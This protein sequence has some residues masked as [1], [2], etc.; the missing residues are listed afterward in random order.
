[1]VARYLRKRSKLFLAVAGIVFS[2]VTGVVDYSAG[3]DTSLEAFYLLSIVGVAFF[4][5]RRAGTATALASAAIAV[6][7]DLK[8]HPAILYWDEVMTL[9]VFLGAAWI[10]AV[11]KRAV[12]REQ[13]LARTDYLTRAANRRAFFETAGNEISRARRYPRPLT[14]AYV[15]LDNFKPVN[16]RFGHDVGDH[17]LCMVTDI[18]KSNT[19]THD[20]VA[21]LGGDEFAILLPETGQEP[22]RVVMDRIHTRLTEAMR[23]KGWPVTF[24]VGVVTFASPPASVDK[25][26][27]H[28]DDLMYAAKRGGKDMILYEVANPSGAAI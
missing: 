28:A 5:G 26:I 14:V 27:K 2:L 24:S 4:A 3:P 1:M 21:R 13:E 22:A 16:D 18:M 19:R 17:L 9:T 10:G 23:A 8:F 25:M 6:I 7:A 11:L 20:I 15:D 12:E